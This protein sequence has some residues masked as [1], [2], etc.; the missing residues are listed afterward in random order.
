MATNGSALPLGG[1]PDGLP[2]IPAVDNTLGALLVGGL[3]A[4]ALWGVTCVQASSF[5]LNGSNDRT[6]HKALV[7][8][9]WALDTFDTILNGHILYFYLISNYFSPQ[10]ILYPVW[11]VILHVAATALSNFIVRGIFA[12]R[13]YRL[14]K[15]NIPGTLLIVALSTTD[16][17]VGITITAKAFGISS[18]L[19]LNSLSSLMYLTFAAGT[20]A[21]L[22]V[23]IALCWLLRQSRTGFK[24][25]D[26]LIRV[27]MTY[28]INTGLLVALDATA[29]MFTY[30]FMPHNFV[31][32]GCFLLLSKLYLNSYLAILNARGRLHGN[33]GPTSIHLSQI[34]GVRWR[35]AGSG[36]GG[37]GGAGGTGIV[38]AYD[39]E[40]QP[41]LG[42]QPALVISK[43]VDVHHDGDA[44]SQLGS[45]TKEA[46]D[47][48]KEKQ[49]SWSSAIEK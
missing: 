34:S 43:V 32:L 28:T 16:L 25:T 2:L 4:T 6:W 18:Y 47:V 41:G 37:A 1:G 13:V 3:A 26:S 8:F 33:D 9:L 14:S 10:E 23:A 29:G 24:R 30:V 22:S 42:S 27:L 20:G 15:G 12:R 7:G 44:E 46:R 49:D 21:D 48:E 36:P 11:S 5:F 35:S 17:V 31:F 38:G 39:V 40:G 45:L 19:E